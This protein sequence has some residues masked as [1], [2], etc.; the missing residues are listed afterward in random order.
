MSIHFNAVRVL[1]LFFISLNA[2][3]EPTQGQL[4]QLGICA[5]Y[6]L[7]YASQHS[8]NAK[9]YSMGIL[10][11]LNKNYSGFPDYKNA[12]DKTYKTIARMISV[13]DPT[14]IPLVLFNYSRSCTRSQIPV[15][16][17]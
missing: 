11:E 17:N 16:I 13:S 9:E 10:D 7:H 12:L 2:Y 5:S 8:G 3:S 15:G 4:Q 1:I 14:E 6:H